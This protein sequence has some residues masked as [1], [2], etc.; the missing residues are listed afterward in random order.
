MLLAAPDAAGGGCWRVASSVR[1]R[2]KT[3]PILSRLEGRRGA[4][5]GWVSC[6]RVRGR[7]SLG[8]GGASVRPPRPL[9]RAQTM[10]SLLCISGLVTIVGCTSSH[11]VTSS[12]SSTAS[13]TRESLRAGLGA[14]F[15]S[16]RVTLS[17]GGGVMRGW[18]GRA[19]ALGSGIER[20]PSTIA[21]DS[22]LLLLES[23]FSSSTSIK[24]ESG[25]HRVSMFG[26]K[27]N[28]RGFE[29]PFAASR[30]N[31]LFSS[32]PKSFSGGWLFAISAESLLVSSITRS[33]LLMISSTSGSDSEGR[34]GHGFVRDPPVAL[35]LPIP[36]G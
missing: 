7:A 19:V 6:A 14:A 16:G 36:S 35:P 22:S 33:A 32:R 4:R 9:S 2:E 21:S 10:T 1:P 27:L 26:A 30:L 20:Q 23:S 5:V 18:R 34:R 15:K 3:P 29:V 28:P 8:E 11:A 17:S 25:E 31:L 12:T 24:F 13:M